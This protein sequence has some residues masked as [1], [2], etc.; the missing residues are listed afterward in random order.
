MR[1]KATEKVKNLVISSGNSL[2]LENAFSRIPCC[3]MI[4]KKYGQAS[5]FSQMQ[6]IA[7]KHKYITGLIF[8]ADSPQL[9]PKLDGEVITKIRES[10]DS[11]FETALWWVQAS[12]HHF[13]NKKKA[14]SIV[15]LLHITSVAPTFYASYCSIAQAALLNFARLAATELAQ[16]KVSV[17]IVIRGWVEDGIEQRVIEGIRLKNTNDNN[18]SAQYVPA[19]EIV[20]ACLMIGATRKNFIKGSILI[21][22]NGSLANNIILPQDSTFE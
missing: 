17:N 12:A 18:I 4:R 14:G 8:V 5:I 2:L 19:S 16:H 6:E 7:S 13:I 3:L 10:F 11:D 21:L 20:Q 15:I 22:D 1:N 9:T